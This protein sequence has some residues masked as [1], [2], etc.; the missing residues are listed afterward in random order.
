MT[1]VSKAEVYNKVMI[2]I[3]YRGKSR[4]KQ[5]LRI[6]WKYCPW[7]W[8][9]FFSW[10]PKLLASWPTLEGWL[11]AL[12][13]PPHAENH[14]ESHEHALSFVCPLILERWPT[15]NFWMT[16]TE[17]TSPLRAC[18]R[19]CVCVSVYA[20]VRCYGE[21]E[22]CVCVRHDSICICLAACVCVCVCVCVWDLE[23]ERSRVV[24][25]W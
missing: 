17:F 18:E 6:E 11:T 21:R 9:A 15:C 12:S 4:F 23:T 10:N 8:K 13:R 22:S 14:P 19:V 7:L 1:S 25:K 5:G 24:I 3:I 20:C 16:S 2:T